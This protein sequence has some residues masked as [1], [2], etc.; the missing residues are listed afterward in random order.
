[1][2]LHSA[3]KNCFNKRYKH[4]QRSISIFLSHSK[5]HNTITYCFARASSPCT[6]QSR[7]LV[8]SAHLT[9]NM[10]IAQVKIVSKTAAS[11]PKSV[12]IYFLN[13]R[14]NHSTITY[15]VAR[16]SSPCTAQSRH[17]S[18]SAHLTINMCIA[19]V[20][21]VSKT[22]ASTRKSVLVYFLNHS[23]NYSTITCHVA[24]A[25]SN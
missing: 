7:H 21:T 22:A 11:T 19:H 5:N 23:K 25:S 6:A 15:H 2:S 8:I 12:L 9:I 18:I 13:H 20:K 16:A 1:M 17:L 14:K 24:R 10:C 4:A 3:C